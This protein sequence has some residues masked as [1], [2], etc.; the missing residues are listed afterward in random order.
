[1][2]PITIVTMVYKPT[3]IT[4]GAQ[5]C[6]ITMTCRYPMINFIP[7]NDPAGGRCEIWIRPEGIQATQ[8]LPGV[9]DEGGMEVLLIFDGL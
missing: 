1:M 7:A 3:N 2:V 6:N 4:G 8:A 9:G 5:P